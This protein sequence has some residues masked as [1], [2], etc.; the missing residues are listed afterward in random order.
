[1]KRLLVATTLVIVLINGLITPSYAIFGVGG[2]PAT[3]TIELPG[4][5]LAKQLGEEVLKGLLHALKKRLL[6][7]MVEQTVYWIQGGGQP[8]FITDWKSFLAQGVNI[9]GG[10]L[11][12]ELGLGSLCRPFGLQLQLALLQP[13]RFSRMIQCTLDQVV[14]NVLGFYEDF[15]RGGFIAYREIWQPQNNFYGALLMTIDEKQKRAAEQQEALTRE[16]QAGGG[17]LSTKECRPKERLGVEEDLTEKDGFV[18][19]TNRLGQS[20]VV[21]VAEGEN[22][23]AVQKQI[24]NYYAQDAQQSPQDYDC[25]ITTPGTTIGATVTTALEGH[26][27]LIINAEDLGAYVAAISDAL[28]NRLIR[29]GVTGL[30]GLATENLP[31][32]SGVVGAEEN[33]DCAGM[34]GTALQSCLSFLSAKRG[35]AKGLQQ[36][37]IDQIDLTLAPLQAAENNLQQSLVLQRALVNKLV[38]LRNCQTNRGQSRGKEATSTELQEEETNLRNLTQALVDTQTI[39]IPLFN[40]K[41]ELQNPPSSE[42][43]DLGLIFEKV[44]NL[45]NPTQANAIQQDEKTRFDQIKIR[46]DQKIPQIQQ[47]IDICAR[48]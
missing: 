44:S 8:M 17:F 15:R 32:A 43:E 19:R 6:D 34:R 41:L 3:G 47:R 5:L 35:N 28:I 38:E 10:D 9:A 1:M 14:G 2:I 24:K 13:P 22:K 21:F 48:N 33:G 18:R 27:N 40:A 23:A 30:R 36:N 37:Y 42:P 16:A 31:S 20:E 7:M 26:Q 45:I 46:T 39:S 4:P 12:I 29:E 25:F 11:L